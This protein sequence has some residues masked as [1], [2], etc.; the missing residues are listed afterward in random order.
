M[1]GDTLR[2]K[3]LTSSPEGFYADSTLIEGEKDAILVDGQFTLSDAHRV[4]AA[5]LESKKN[6]TAIYV[7]H[8]HP[9]HF[10]GL[11]VLKGVFPKARIVA[12]PST[13][14]AIKNTWESDVKTWKPTYGD[15]IPSN[16]VIPEALTGTTLTLEGET[17]QIFGGLQG[18]ARNNS[19]IWM[20]SF[21]TAVCGDIVFNGVH[22]WTLETTPAERKDWIASLD[23]IAAHKPAVVVAGHK[24]PERKDD[25]SCLDFSKDYLRF[26]DEMLAVCKSA[27]EFRSKVKGRFPDLGLEVVLQM[28][29]DAA[30]ARKKAA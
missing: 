22:L 24:A 15:N 16:P 3:V 25:P 6:L 17:L 26:Y 20:P 9:D 8:F 19:Y 12:L 23:R 28:A 13:V 21:K 30:Y 2:I 4:A 10:F 27:E 1:R 5:V 14:D 18:D 29:S 11:T 7:T